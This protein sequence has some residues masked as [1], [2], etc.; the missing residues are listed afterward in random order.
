MKQSGCEA[1]TFPVI[2]SGESFCMV[3]NSDRKVVLVQFGLHI[4]SPQ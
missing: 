3:L 4:D 1:G 2:V